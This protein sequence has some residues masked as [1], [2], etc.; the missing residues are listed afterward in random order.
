MAC[1]ETKHSSSPCDY[2][3]LEGSR[4]DVG[5]AGV[6]WAIDVAVPV[7][8]KPSALQYRVGTEDLVNRLPY[9]ALT[10]A[11]HCNVH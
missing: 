9:L 4:L 2:L 3:L 6:E 8:Q 10:A 7:E 5:A 11:I 1:A